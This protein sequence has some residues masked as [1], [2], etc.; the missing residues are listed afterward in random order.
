MEEQ[1]K[2][3]I[4][5][6]AYNGEKYLREQIDS[7]LNQTYPN[8]EILIRD[9]GSTDRTGELLKEYEEQ[10]ANIR[11]FSEENIGLVGS[12]FRLLE[13]SDADYVGFCDQDDV[14]MERK[15][16]RAV[17]A[18]DGI[19]EPAMYCGNKMLVNSNL[20]E[21]GTSDAD[22]IRPGFGNAVIENIAT[23]CTILLNRKLAELIRQQIPE[24]A[25]L[26]DWW[27]YL[28]AAYH[29]RVIYD[30]TPYIYYRQ[31]ENNQVG[32]SAGFAEETAAKRKYLKKSRGKLKAQLLEFHRF[33]HDDEKK[34][35]LL[36][37]VLETESFSGKIS[38]I[39]NSGIY[40]QKKLDNLIVRGL[41]MT[42]NML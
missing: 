28:L 37:N 32:G 33:Y 9:D 34:D 5:L 40:R 30:K 26:H 39:F 17:H 36:L 23:G 20:E 25:V 31:H 2:V 13:L 11:V 16:E 10:Y 4:L 42:N 29:G 1:D 7:L 18:L 15:V 27:C 38:M 22:N 35:R 3:Q 19:E 41:F 14:W 8:L 24:H 21:I 6:S 12:F